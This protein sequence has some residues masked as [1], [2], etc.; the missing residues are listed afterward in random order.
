MPQDTAGRRLGDDKEKEN[1][2]VSGNRADSPKRE[3]KR[4]LNGKIL[5][6]TILNILV[7][8]IVCC[9]IMAVAMQS[10]AN[11]ILLDSMQPMARQSAKTVEANIH[12]LADRMMSIAADSR[13]E[14]AAAADPETGAVSASLLRTNR[15]LVLTEAAEV[16]E[17]HTIALYDLNGRLLQGISGA[18]ESLNSS[19]FALLK[20]TDNLTTDASTWFQNQ[21]GITMGMPVKSMWSVSTSTTRLTM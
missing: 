18:P 8:V 10:L 1:V 7:L 16:Y 6:N 3:I 17:F 2:D 21:L 14:E 4:S 11:S 9:V 13:M 5:K 20:E 19:F 15:N 12:M